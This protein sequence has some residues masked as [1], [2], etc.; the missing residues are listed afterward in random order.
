MIKRFCEWWLRRKGLGTYPMDTPTL[1]VSGNVLVDQ[2]PEGSWLVKFEDPHNV[3]LAALNNSTI[4]ITNLDLLGFDPSKAI[5]IK[6]NIDGSMTYF[7]WRKS[8]VKA[9]S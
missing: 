8:G 5:T 1:M 7:A 9:G 2:T 4:H 6:Y 3:F